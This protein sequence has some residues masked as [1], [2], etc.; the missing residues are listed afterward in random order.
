MEA[1]RLYVM[2]ACP[3]CKKVT[4]YMDK[5][6]INIQVVDIGEANHREDLL[7]LG[8]QVQVPALRKD[9]KIMYES[10]DIVKYLKENFK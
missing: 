1:Y 2:K 5:H 3:F 7:S 10:S 9:D 4:R 8:G 6:N